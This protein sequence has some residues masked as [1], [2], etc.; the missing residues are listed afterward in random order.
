MEL[1]EGTNWILSTVELDICV[2]I[3]GREDWTDFPIVASEEALG[4]RML[5]A[6]LHLVRMGLIDAAG[7]GYVGTERMRRRLET[8]AWPDWSVAL[9]RGGTPVQRLY[10]RQGVLCLVEMLEEGK[11]RISLRK[12]EEGFTLPEKWRKVA[13]KSGQE[14]SAGWLELYDSGGKKRAYSAEVLSAWIAGGE[15][16]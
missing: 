2:R 4:K 8:V 11:C 3:L 10:S 7:T 16:P 6:F 5:D 1:S 9:F 15:T 14:P 12:A 13:E